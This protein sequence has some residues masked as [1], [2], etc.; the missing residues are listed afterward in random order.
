MMAVLTAGIAMLV[1]CGSSSVPS[2]SAPPKQSSPATPFEVSWEVVIDE[3]NFTRG[4][5]SEGSVQ[6]GK[7]T[8]EIK[9][10]RVFV[11]GKDGGLLKSG[12]KVLL[13]KDGR[14]SVNGEER[15]PK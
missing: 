10:G 2:A 4:D 12:D 11:N 5:G 8:L 6:V 1:G 7:N 13:D 9:D 15:T 14:L 3:G